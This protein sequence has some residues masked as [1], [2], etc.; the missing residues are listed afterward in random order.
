MP[1]DTDDLEFTA[2]DREKMRELEYLLREHG[3]VKDLRG[4][5]VTPDRAAG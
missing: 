3:Y 4:F 2:A 5:W 1:T